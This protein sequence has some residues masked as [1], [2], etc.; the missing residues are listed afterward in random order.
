MDAAGLR[1]VRLTRIGLGAEDLI[2]AGLVAQ[3]IGLDATREAG[4]VSGQV[5]DKVRGKSGPRSVGPA[6]VM[7]F[8]RAA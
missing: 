4:L 5:M 3:R 8:R 1:R 6:A 2:D 7:P